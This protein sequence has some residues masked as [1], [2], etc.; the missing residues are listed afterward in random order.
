MKKVALAIIILLLAALLL[1]GLRAF[2]ETSA[3][4]EEI[5]HDISR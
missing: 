2:E 4:K 1:A 5:S 3:Q